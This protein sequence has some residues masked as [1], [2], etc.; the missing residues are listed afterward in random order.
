MSCLSSPEHIAYG[1]PKTKPYEP[2]NQEGHI[3]KEEQSEDDSLD[4]TTL[5]QKKLE[6]YVKDIEAIKSKAVKIFCDDAAQP[7]KWSTEFNEAIRPKLTEEAM[8][9]LMSKLAKQ[10]T[11]VLALDTLYHFSPSRQLIFNHSYQ[12]LHASVMVS[13]FC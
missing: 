3:N 8:K 11:W 13:I 4:L 1:T 12:K 2:T 10:V 7:S 5:V 9:A 6:E